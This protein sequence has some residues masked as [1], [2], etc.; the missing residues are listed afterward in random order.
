MLDKKSTLLSLAVALTLS[1]CG[2]GS[3][4]S[5][6]TVATPATTSGKAVDGYLS[7][8]AVLCDTNK[9]GVADAGETVVLTDGAGNFTFATACAS[10]IVVSGGTNID[11]GLPFTG[12]IKAPAGSTVATPLTS[13]MVDAGLT[14]AQVA[15]FVG[16]AVGSD[17]TKIDPA[18]TTNGV[19]TNPDVLKKTLALQQIIQQTTNTIAAL[20]KNSTTASLQ[21]IYLE[22]VKAVAATLVAN[23]SATLVDSTGGVSTVLVTTIVSQSVTNVATTSNPALATVKGLIANYS[24]TRI[25]TVAAA[26]IS[27]GAH[28]LATSTNSNDLTKLIQSDVTISNTLNAVSTL[29]GTTSTQTLIGLDTAL[30]ALASANTAIIIDPVAAAA[31]KSAAATALSNQAK[32]SDPTLTIDATKLGAPTNYLSISNDQIAINGTTY[33]LAQ[34]TSGIAIIT[35]K[36]ANLDTFAFTF[37]VNG[38]PVPAD[39]NG[40]QTATVSIALELTDTVASKRVLQVAIDKVA[41]TIDANKQIGISVPANA[42]VYVY[43]QTRSGVN[44][45]LTLSNVASNLVSVDSN[46]GVSFNMG[47]LF[48][49]IASTNQNAVLTDLQNATGTLNVTFVMSNLDLRTSNAKPAAGLSVLVTGAG[50]PAVSGQGVKGIVTVQQ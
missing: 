6:Q 31:A 43:G 4:G 25:A 45:N 36:Q 37:L 5:T 17:P 47:L 21:V 34:F 9:N 49:K 46:N 27:A 32:A 2:G 12:I 40:V 22:V 23:P 41:I 1:A 7:N 50:Q 19:L 3:G 26:A 30:S 35:A 10:N 39:V 8:S 20:G 33:T 24:P 11:T 14:A 29:L 38:T 42:K 18:A 13:L 44:A 15:A 48:S 28:T 16:L